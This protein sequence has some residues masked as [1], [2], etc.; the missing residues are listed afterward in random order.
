MFINLQG[1]LCKL[2]PTLAKQNGLGIRARR[3]LTQEYKI[4]KIHKEGCTACRRCS[5]VFFKDLLPLFYGFFG[6]MCMLCYFAFVSESIPCYACAFQ[7]VSCCFYTYRCTYF[8]TT[9]I[10]NASR[11][12]GP[13]FTSLKFGTLPP[14]AESGI[15]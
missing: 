14:P 13:C 11:V 15:C 7:N 10:K 1:A 12:H 6:S 5:F 8:S 4:D 3:G 9:Q 2:H